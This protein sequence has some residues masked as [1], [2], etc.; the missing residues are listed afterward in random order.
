MRLSPQ[1]RSLRRPPCSGLLSRDTSPPASCCPQH[2]Q[3]SGLPCACLSTCR[4]SPE[5]PFCLEVLSNNRPFPLQG[6]FPCTL[7]GHALSVPQW[8]SAL[9]HVLPLTP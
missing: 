5:A 7:S 1:P 4:G 8:E 9:L 2:H 6:I 3:P